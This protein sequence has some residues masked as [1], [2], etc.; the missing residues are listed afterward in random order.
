[1]R[2]VKFDRRT[3]LD[4]PLQEVKNEMS[5][6]YNN[7]CK[8][9]KPFSQLNSSPDI[10]IRSKIIGDFYSECPSGNYIGFKTTRSGV[11]TSLV[12]KSLRNNETFLFIAP[13][14]KIIDETV[15]RD[16]V[17]YSGRVLQDINIIHIPANHKCKFNK[18]Q[19]EECPDLA[20]LPVLPL[21]KDCEKCNEI[22]CAN[23][24]IL[25]E[26]NFDGICLTYDKLE[27]LMLRAIL[28]PESKSV[29]ILS[30]IKECKNIIFDEAH[31]LLFNKVKTL[32][33]LDVLNGNKSVDVL[34]L[35]KYDRVKTKFNHISKILDAFKELH[36]SITKYGYIKKILNNLV[37]TAIKQNNDNYLCNAIENSRYDEYF[38]GEVFLRLF[39]NEIK[40]LM[41]TR[42][43]FKLDIE[44]VT[45]LYTIAAIM[46]NN[47]FS[48]HGIRYNADNINGVII[49][50][51][52]I[53]LNFINTIKSFIA[54]VQ[55]QNKRVIL[56][57]ATFGSYDY[58][59][60]FNGMELQYK[61]FGENGDPLNAN[62]KMLILADSKK[63]TAK[64][65]RSPYYKETFKTLINE[66]I[67]I[68]DIYGDANCMIITQNGKKSGFVSSKLKKLG[69]NADVT[70]YKSNKVMGVS[71]DHRVCIA[72][73]PAYKPRNG[74]DVIIN[75]KFESRVMSEESKHMDT[76]QAWSRVKDPE[77]KAAIPV[78]NKNTRGRRLNFLIF[79]NNFISL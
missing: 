47:E 51:S 52:V 20:K 30:I 26:D 73:E 10:D 70:Y 17:E 49:N 57:S 32:P 60:L 40:E 69:R 64:G 44:D 62:S 4:I 79:R 65:I 76:W 5:S 78:L 75:T 6:I 67:N 54:G 43:E 59:S 72:I 7:D 71:S 53:D 37:N 29:K 35:N 74:F 23:S 36:N 39:Y 12:A 9:Y 2:E 46:Q 16:A 58:S 38:S 21:I 45:D 42:E 11:T 61:I 27:A 77:G 24:R 13:T 19:I 33:I 63:S 50:L 28:D 25:R 3:S 15:I 66:I 34:T 41:K 8:T 22:N 18:E 31:H 68:L 14:N 1:L 48:I 56:T 55:N